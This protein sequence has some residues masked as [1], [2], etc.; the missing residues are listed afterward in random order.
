MKWIKNLRISIKLL[1]G[2][3]AITM[4]AVI[5]G[6]VGIGSMSDME[7][8]DKELYENMTIPVAQLG[9]LFEQFNK[10]GIYVRKMI[11]TDN[12]KEREDYYDEV[13]QIRVHSDSIRDD[14]EKR[15]LT[16]DMRQAYGEF[17]LTQE[18]YRVATNDLMKG[19]TNTPIATPLEIKELTR[20]YEESEIVEAAA[21]EKLLNMKLEDAKG[22]YEANYQKALQSKNVLLAT[23]GVT[24]IIGVLIA[25]DLNRIIAT[26]IRY[27]SKVADALAQGDMTAEVVLDRKDEIGIL[28]KSLVQMKNNIN[29]MLQDIDSAS[30]Q[31]TIGAR[32]VSLASVDLAQGATDQASAAQQL[33]AS[34]TEI[35]GQTTQNAEYAIK[36]KEA[37]IQAKASAHLGD[38][39]M[40]QMIVAMNAITET[41]NRISK[42]IKVID[43]I[44]FQTNILA[45]NAAVEAARAGD[46][47][48]GFAVVAEE[49]RKLAARSAQAANETTEMIEEAILRAQEGKTMTLHVASTLHDILNTAEETTYLVTAITAAANEQ[50]MAITQINQGIEQV[51]DVITTNSASAQQSA[52]ASQELYGH[53]ELLKTLVARFNL[54]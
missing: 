36:A 23:L 19:L 18:N 6:A 5:V 21:I 3:L 28:A 54:E 33:T 53:A 15:I 34:M 27:M 22:K 32:Q 38:Q 29:K 41:S 16:E 8:V 30:E 7:K 45:L 31:M 50:A 49:V 11:I 13:M 12:Q 2:F 46:S 52:S 25:I 10:Q 9:M 24:A 4:L 37:S 35:A 43:N 40:Q 26:P 20:V 1:S 39:E 42:V 51:T 44:A 48:R 14:F 17:M 47:G